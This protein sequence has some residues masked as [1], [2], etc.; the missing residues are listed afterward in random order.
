M[1]RWWTWGLVYFSPG[2][3]GLATYP[4]AVII[5]WTVFGALR[6]FFILRLTKRMGI[7]IA[8]WLGIEERAAVTMLAQ[9]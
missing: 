2:A 3:V 8:T 6:M 7:D 4:L 5:F 9:R 1:R